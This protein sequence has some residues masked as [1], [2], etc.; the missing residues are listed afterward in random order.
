M[1]QLIISLARKNRI[2]TSLLLVLSNVFL[3]KQNQNVL[4]W[5]LV[6]GD[7]LLRINYPLN[8][9]SVVFDV[10]GYIGNWSNDIY[11][12]YEC[13][14]YIFEPV[15]EYYR[16][17]KNRFRRVKKIRVLN[18]GLAARTTYVMLHLAKDATS[19][20]GQSTKLEKVRLANIKDILH[21]YKI[22]MVDLV[23]LNIEGGE[24]DLLEYL[25]EADMIKKF[26]NIQVQFHRS[27]ND[28]EERRNKIQKALRKTHKLTYQYS[29]VWENWL[30][31]A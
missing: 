16:I 29:F 20:Y 31:K 17:T 8:S 10:G 27:V 9:E 5:K 1:F 21:R 11:E 22:K 26:K 4:R 12:K 3:S 6:N 19:A 30:R 18:C 2:L 24:Y 7:K 25:I 13:Y 28:F 15:Q 14:I 23:K